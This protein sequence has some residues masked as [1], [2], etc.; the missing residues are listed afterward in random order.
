M[1]E[2]F[3][4]PLFVSVINIVFWIFAVLHCLNTS[5]RSAENLQQLQFNLLRGEYINQCKP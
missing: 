4:L 1:Y 5:I 2:V 3:V